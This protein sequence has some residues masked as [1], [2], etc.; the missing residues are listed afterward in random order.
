MLKQKFVTLVASI[1]VAFLVVSTASAQQ[2]VNIG[3]DD[4]Y[5]GY[6]GPAIVW[7]T[8]LPDMGACKSA[9]YY[10]PSDTHLERYAV[11][12]AGTR[13]QQEDECRWEDTIYSWR[14]ILRPAGTVIAVDAQGRDL[15]D[16]GSPNGKVC[17][18]PT[19]IGVPIKPPT[20]PT[21]PPAPPAYVPPTPPHYEPPVTVNIPPGPP[22]CILNGSIEEGFT[23]T[24]YNGVGEWI[25]DDEKLAVN[26]DQPV[27]LQHEQDPGLHNLI[28]RVTANDGR[29]MDCPK[30]WEVPVAIT[31]IPPDEV[32][33]GWCEAG[34]P[35]YVTATGVQIR[36]HPIRTAIIL[37]CVGE[38]VYSGGTGALAP[39]CGKWFHLGAAK[40]LTKAPVKV[41]IINP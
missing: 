36:C 13:I 29:T 3:P 23:G 21:P 38:A 11:N 33:P 18:N 39:P 20:K 19:P 24:A 35:W 34:H 8:S 31:E 28:Y 26:G 15:F 40:I 22:S 4:R 41:P 16:Y 1:L 5:M 7:P 17:K 14:W 37:A 9:E 2:T 12:V 6:H 30:N 25:G 27:H 10:E 32:A